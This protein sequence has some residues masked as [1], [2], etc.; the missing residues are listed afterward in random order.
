[1]YRGNSNFGLLQVLQLKGDS[2]RMYLNDYLVQ[3]IY[4]TNLQKSTTMFTYM[5]HD[6][7]RAYTA[8]I[9]D[10]LCIGLGIGIVPMEF[11]REGARVDVVEINPD[12]VPVGQKFFGLEP[13]RMKIHMGD[14][15]HYVAT[16]SKQYDTVILDAFLGDSSPAHL[17]TREAFTGMRRLLRPA[18]V[19]VINCFGDFESGQDFFVASLE[20]T[21]KTVFP[22]LRIHNESNGGNVLMVASQSELHLRAPAS[23]EHVHPRCRHLVEGAFSRIV[24]TIPEHGVVLTD[25]YNPVEFYDAANREQIRKNLAFSM[26]DF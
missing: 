25:D 2:R 13:S 8:R 11:A 22:H 5:L 23:F 9:D 10:V 15:R 4:D 6:L 26:R 16:S 19:L 17:M 18:G 3:N 14:G 12:V 24:E 7:A 21:L 1:L 20:K